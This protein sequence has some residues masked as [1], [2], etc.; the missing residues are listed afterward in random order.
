MVTMHTLLVTRN[1]DKSAQHDFVDGDYTAEGD[2][3]VNVSHS[4]LNYK[5]AMALN[6]DKGVMRVDPLV[7]GIDVIGT[8]EK[9]D[10]ERLAAGTLV[11]ALG[12]GLGEFRHGGYTPRQLVN[13]SATVKVPSRFSAAQAAAIGTA[14]YTAALCVNA[15][16]DLEPGSRLLVSG[17]TG[18]VGSI[19]VHLLAQLGHEVHAITGRPSEQSD[20]LKKL[21]AKEI[22]DR[23]DFSEQS[24]PL[25]KAQ[26]DAAIDT[27]GS[28]VLANILANITWG[29]VVANTGM[30]AGPDL[31][32]TVLPFILRNVHL[33]GVNSVDA[34]LSYREAAWKLL[35]E[36]L[37]TDLL[38]SFTETI[39]LKD[40]PG[41]ASDLLAG[42]R[43]GRTVVKIDA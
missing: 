36:H 40:T 3:L 32:A 29:G 20:Y 33:H 11:A 31:P 22:V 16:G 37:D 1:E 2:I 21:G 9:S 41:A 25:Q 13:A 17:A 5:D 8:V 35:D 10:D 19:A 30:A 14:G 18:G 26:Y 6:A 42:K 24:R 15:L 23:S 34:P 27:A 7:P 38:D 4:S 43:H 28:H 39:S 12:D